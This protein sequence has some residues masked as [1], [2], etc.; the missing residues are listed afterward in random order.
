MAERLRQALTQ[1]EWPAGLAVTASWGVAQANDEAGIDLAMRE[2]DQA[3]Y[4]AKHAGRD[5]VE[6]AAR[7]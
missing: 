7:A 5:R 4:R 2:A 1:V 3:M 6:R